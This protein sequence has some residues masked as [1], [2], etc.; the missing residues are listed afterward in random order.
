VIKVERML[1]EA[2]IVN[3]KIHHRFF[4]NRLRK[5]TKR[6]LTTVGKLELTD[7]RHG[8]E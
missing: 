2:E 3:F 4:P 7:E 8:N 5:A 1:K 6:N